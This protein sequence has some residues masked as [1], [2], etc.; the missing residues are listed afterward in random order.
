[1]RLSKTDTKQDYASVLEKQLYKGE[2]C[3]E[4]IRV[5]GYRRIK[6]RVCLDGTLPAY[7]L[8]PVQTTGLYN[9]RSV[10]ITGEIMLCMLRRFSQRWPL[11]SQNL[12]QS[13]SVLVQ[14]R[15][16]PHSVSVIEMSMNDS[17]FRDS[18]P[19]FFVNKSKSSPGNTI[20]KVAGIDWNFNSWGVERLP[21]FPQSIILEGGS[22][23]VDGEGT[24]LTTEE[25]LLNKN[26]NPHL[27]KCYLPHKTSEFLRQH[28]EEELINL[29]GNG[30]D[31]LNEWDRVYDYAYY[32]DLGSP[33]KGTEYARPVL[34]GSKEY[35]YPRRGRTGRKQTKNDNSTRDQSYINEF[36]SFQDVFDLYE[37]G[38]DLPDGQKLSK[39]RECIP[40]EMLKELVPSSSSSCLMSLKSQPFIFKLATAYHL[41][42]QS[43]IFELAIFPKAE[44]FPVGKGNE[45]TPPYTLTF[46]V[47]DEEGSMWCGLFGVIRNMNSGAIGP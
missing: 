2:I 43:F 22:I 23:H 8:N 26:R 24:C 27:T 11:L 31:I 9:L 4:V 34:G 19:T 16:L 6:R 18:G 3:R 30:S 25:C 12:S 40:W 46:T 38:I 44:A 45:D 36:D 15:Q 42:S 32:N 37:G 47:R 28:R 14:L 1:M 7:R 20:Y 39:L 29:R 21:R 5:P 41:F 33:E 35:P 13:P 10:V 17:W